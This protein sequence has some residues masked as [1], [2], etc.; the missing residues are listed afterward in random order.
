VLRWVPIGYQ[1]VILPEGN[2]IYQLR[3]ACTVEP[4]R[5]FISDPDGSITE[6]KLV[7]PAEYK[8]YFD[9]GE[10]GE[11]IIERAVNVKKEIFDI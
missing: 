6:I 7:S 2:I 1:K 3:V 8:T 9:W 11:R 5:D 4:I 10:I